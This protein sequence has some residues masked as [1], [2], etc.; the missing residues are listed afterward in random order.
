[1]HYLKAKVGT[2][3]DVCP[4]RDDFLTGTGTN[5]ALVEVESVEVKGHSADA[6]SSKPDPNDLSLIHI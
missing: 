1:M 5:D 2:V 3:Q 6:K 4:C